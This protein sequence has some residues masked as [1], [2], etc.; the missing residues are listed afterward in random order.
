M[1]TFQDGT[2]HVEISRIKHG[3]YKKT[4]PVYW[5]PIIKPE[6]RNSIDDLNY[7]FGDENFR[8]RF[9]L[10]GG[11]SMAI[12]ESLENDCV[13]EKFQQKHFKCK[14]FIHES[15]NTEMDLSGTN[16]TFDFRFPPN[17]DSYGWSTFVCGNS[18]AG[19][20]RW[21]ADQI[22]KNL[23]GPKKDRRHF[24]YISN[25]L[26]ID[27]TLEP[28]KRDKY[29]DRFQGI[30]ISE[31]SL[32]ESGKSP[33]DFFLTAV[34]VHIDAAPRGSI[35]IADDAPDAHPTVAELMR[36]II[37]RL[38]RVGR[39]SGVGLIFL[40]HKLSSGLWSSQ[41]YSSARYIV[42]FPRSMKNK[43]RD[44]FEKE[45]GLTRKE[46]KRHLHDF[47]QTGRAM[48]CRMHSPSAFMNDKLI[49]LL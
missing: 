27:K 8:D 20:T 44:L 31:Q 18:G 37:I 13:C 45:I 33:H 40:L 10:S 15:L 4:T 1:L 21:V 9:E 7:Y 35:V 29:R 23:N 46:A 38:Q 2:E 26:H 22:E 24:I 11:Q 28:L 12:K 43:I 30:D 48:I 41:A 16:Q 19:K 34:K 17:G 32:K 25:E 3:K 39:H 36:N 14:R 42:V 6:L 47:S 5:S 49:R